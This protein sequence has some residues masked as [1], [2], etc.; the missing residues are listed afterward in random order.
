MNVQ[1]ITKPP[2]MEPHTATIDNNSSFMRTQ[3]SLYDKCAIM[4]HLHMKQ[5]H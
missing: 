5:S 2:T 1:K 3:L 4:L